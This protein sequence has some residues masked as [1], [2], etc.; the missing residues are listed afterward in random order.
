MRKTH[1]GN[2][3][4]SKTSA[5]L[6]MYRIR[7]GELEALLVHPGGPFW[8]KKDDGAWFIPKGELNP[9]EEPLAGAKR[10]FAEETGLTPNG[11][12]VPLGSAKQKSGKII[13]AWAFAG[14]CDA[15]TIQSNTFTMEWPPRSGT[16]REFPE[17]D[18]AAFF[19]LEQAARKMHP[20]EF[21]F[22]ERLRQILRE[23]S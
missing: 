11:P 12:F 10:E 8:A 19:T 17:I 5:G 9:S 22:L 3:A 16:M 14:D 23:D 2:L 4:M 7:D 21:P 1:H 18:R 15:A 13:F 6:V 20:V